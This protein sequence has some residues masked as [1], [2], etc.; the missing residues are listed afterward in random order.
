MKKF[1]LT[2]TLC[3]LIFSC[4]KCDKDVICVIAKKADLVLSAY[5]DMFA[6]EQNNSKFYKISH[7]ILNSVGSFA[8]CSVDTAAENTFRESLVYS[9]DGN[10]TN[11]NVE[12][13]SDFRIKQLPANKEAK[14]ID[15][16][17]FDVDGYYKISSVIDVNNDVP[18]RDDANNDNDNNV[19]QLIAKPLEHVIHI[20]G[21]RKKPLKDPNG[22]P[23]YFK[24]VS[25]AIIYN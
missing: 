22:K 21:T 1:L 10:F 17:S 18:E 12:D 16:I 9:E 25:T 14:I 8:E 19:G 7:T 3:A 6:G 5:N 20:T 23:I 15:T 4:D 13:M 24:R 11:S 2:I